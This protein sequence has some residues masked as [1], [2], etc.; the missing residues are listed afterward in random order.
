MTE[1]AFSSP[2]APTPR[3]HEEVELDR[4]NRYKLPSS[5]GNGQ[6]AWQRVTTFAKLGA[7]T[8]E[9][10]L[11]QQR[12]VAKG[13][14]LR[15]DLYALAASTPISYREK[16][17]R[18]AS[19]AQEAAGAKSGSN[20][21]SAMHAFTEAVDRGEDVLIPAPWDRDVAAYTAA[22]ERHGI[23]TVPHLIERIV[24]NDTYQVAGKFD[25]VV[26]HG[27]RLVIADLKT[28]KNIDYAWGEIATQLACYAGAQEMYDRGA[29]RMI[30]APEMS[31]DYALVFH[32]P[33]GTAKCTVYRVDLEE[34]R[35][36]ADLCAL[37]RERRKVRGIAVPQKVPEAPTAVAETVVSKETLADQIAS[38][39]SSD[40]LRELWATNKESWRP[41]HTVLSRARI[42]VISS[43]QKRG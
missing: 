39:S 37:I 30:P 14:A 11:W 19:D 15:P 6:V 8:Y 41:E 22:L 24:R 1:D 23:T 38:A 33:V 28:G 31:Q 25:R 4:W 10:G 17:N 42:A 20:N 26:N 34:G 16:M 29:N 13:L 2:T 35:R 3:A 21:G 43:D 5:S 40:A 18:I 32:L 9:L 7:D 12:M 27:G 36:G